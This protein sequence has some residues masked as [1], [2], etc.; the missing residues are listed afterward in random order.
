MV[1]QM[2]DWHVLPYKSTI[3]S[4]RLEKTLGRHG[5]NR[6]KASGQRQTKVNGTRGQ[7][8]TSQVATARIKSGRTVAL[9][10]DG[11]AQ[12]CLRED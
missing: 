11:F 4:Q 9:R 2:G 6:L 7:T 12:A 3:A 10:F 5:S 1:K 8:V